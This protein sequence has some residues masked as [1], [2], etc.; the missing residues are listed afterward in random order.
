M[1]FSSK[2]RKLIYIC[3]LCFFILVFLVSAVFIAEYMIDSH[4]AGN[5]YDD[6]SDQREQLLATLT[7][8]TGPSESTPPPTDP[9]TGEPIVTEPEI[10]PEYLPFYQ[11]NSDMVGW[12]K[13]PDTKV[14]Y[15]VV[16]SP[17]DNPDFYLYRRFDKLWSD[18][19]A[20]YCRPDTDVNIPSD[21]VVLYGHH[22]LDG[23]MFTGLDPYRKKDFW[24]AHQTLTF[25]TLYE[26]HTYQ[27]WAAFKTSANEDQ[28]F[29]YHRFLNAADEE[30]FNQFVSTIKSL[31]LYETG[32]TPQYGDKLLLMSTCEYILPNGRFIVCAVRVDE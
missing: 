26:H 3:L 21:S 30:E 25:D 13:I 24:E 15:P 5:T 16:R 28:G 10:L 8:P 14:D 32:I 20:I 27:V 12:L 6:L 17:E 23:S 22:M 11:Q 9:S 2:N 4:R 19:G 1:K 29:M 7:S 31:Q 18:W